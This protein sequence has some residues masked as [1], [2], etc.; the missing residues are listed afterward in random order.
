MYKMYKGPADLKQILGESLDQITMVGA[1]PERDGFFHPPSA[2]WRWQQTK[3]LVMFS[4]LDFQI[5][6]K[7]VCNALH[8][9]SC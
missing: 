1:E 8:Q 2:T 7:A 4:R 6:S 5:L 9:V 3:S